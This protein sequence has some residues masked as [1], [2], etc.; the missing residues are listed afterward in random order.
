[1]SLLKEEIGQTKINS[2]IPFIPYDVKGIV[3]DKHTAKIC[4]LEWSLFDLI[5][6]HVNDVI[7]TI[8]YSV[9]SMIERNEKIEYKIS[10]GENVSNSE[11]NTLIRNKLLIS[12]SDEMIEYIQLNVE[13]LTSIARKINWFDYKKLLNEKREKKLA[14]E[15]AKQKM[16]QKF[17]SDNN[18]FEE[19]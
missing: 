5:T 17:S 1:M 18:D 11:I 8:K 10:I 15:L 14:D 4:I 13:D 9:K 16:R 12:V 3:S 7:K 2:I 6:S 19:I